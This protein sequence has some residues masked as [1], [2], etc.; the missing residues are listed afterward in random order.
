MCSLKFMKTTVILLFMTYQTNN[1]NKMSFNDI[2]SDCRCLFILFCLCICV[3]PNECTNEFI[4]YFSEWVPLSIFFQTF[5]LCLTTE[6]NL[7]WWSIK[8]LMRSEAINMSCLVYAIV[9][10]FVCWKKF[11]FLSCK[12]LKIIPFFLNNL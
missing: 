8:E 10:V 7:I 12:M 4:L 11:S 2:I 3:Y 5:S 9:V 1:S 6:W